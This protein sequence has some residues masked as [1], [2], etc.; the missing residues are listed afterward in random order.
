LN[1][2]TTDFPL[3]PETG[4]PAQTTGL[5]AACLSDEPQALTR[6]SR[7]TRSASGCSPR[8]RLRR[9]RK[10]DG[11]FARVSAKPELIRRKTFRG[12][13]SGCSPRR[14][15]RRLR[16]GD[17]GF[18]RVSA[19]PELIRRKTLR[20]DASGCSPRRRL[21][22]LR[23]GDA[24]FARVSAKPELIRRKTLRGDASGCS[25]SRIRRGRPAPAPLRLLRP[26]TSGRNRT[27]PRHSGC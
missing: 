12:D 11:G 5:E 15:L 17:A 18:A 4:A 13:A 2:R 7:G 20:G 26:G 9:L 10:G 1:R 16:K 8:R 19:K 3:A 21:R 24:G 22:R 23:K 25:L 6:K 27:T 14:R